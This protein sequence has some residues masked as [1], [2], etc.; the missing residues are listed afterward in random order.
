MKRTVA[1]YFMIVIAAG[2]TG[3]ASTRAYFVDRGRDAA[4]VVTLTGG[5][6]LGAGVRCSFFQTGLGAY[7]DELGLRNGGFI[8]CPGFTNEAT[9]QCDFNWLLLGGT[10]APPVDDTMRR[11]G[12]SFDAYT[13]L[14]IFPGKDL[15]GGYESPRPPHY[16][17][18]VEVNLGAG[19][20]LTQA[21]L[22]ISYSGGRQSISSTTICVQYNQKRRRT[23]CR[24]IQLARSPILSTERSVL[25][26]RT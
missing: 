9:L 13:A 3:C 11:R 20:N 16:Y 7:K 14:L 24:R 17:T 21:N 22:W 12:K 1:L 5:L 18:Q 2:M 25:G 4:D 8:L 15:L 10:M 6:G 19:R 26:I 23:K